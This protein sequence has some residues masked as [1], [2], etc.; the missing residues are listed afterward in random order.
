MTSDDDKSPQT[1]QQEKQDPTNRARQ[2]V[3]GH[4][5][6]YVLFWSVLALLVGYG[7]IV[8]FFSGRPERHGCP[9]MI[10]AAAPFLPPAHCKCL[11]FGFSLHE[12]N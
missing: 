1:R 10:D 5:V 4:N 11:C 2:G 3:T 7:L 6:R 12:A 9:V 8:V